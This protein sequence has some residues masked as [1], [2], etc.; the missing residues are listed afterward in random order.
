MQ[1]LEG[2]RREAAAVVLNAHT[3]CH[4]HGAVAKSAT[5]LSS[6]ESPDDEE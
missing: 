2:R 4:W 1:D 3:H 6:P 5:A